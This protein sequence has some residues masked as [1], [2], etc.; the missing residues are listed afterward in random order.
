VDGMSDRNIEDQFLKDVARH[1]MKVIRDDGT[2][3]HLRF[4]NPNCGS[5]CF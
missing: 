4:A 2:H 1:Q 5:Y 3:R